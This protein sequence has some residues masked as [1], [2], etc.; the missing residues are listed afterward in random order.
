MDLA[1]LT[2]SYTN[3]GSIFFT[4]F[5]SLLFYELSLNDGKNRRKLRAVSFQLFLTLVLLLIVVFVVK[6]ATNE[7]RPCSGEDGCEWG[8]SFPSFHSANAFGVALLITLA[9]P[10]FG[11]LLFPLAVA[12]AYSRVA[13]NVHF[14]V[15]TIAGAAIGLAVARLISKNF[16]KIENFFQKYINTKKEQTFTSR[17]INTLDERMSHNLQEGQMMAKKKKKKK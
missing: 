12:V 5:L 4:L 7:A 15:D 3:V 11:L 9:Y 6:F 13:L 8:P 2:A 1:S 10:R 14:V 16:D 17:D